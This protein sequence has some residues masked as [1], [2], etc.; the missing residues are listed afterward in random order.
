MYFEVGKLVSKFNE[1]YMAVII[2]NRR[3][4]HSKNHKKTEDD[5]N[6]SSFKFLDNLFHII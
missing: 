6:C 1:S 4:Q 5:V 3:T 2:F